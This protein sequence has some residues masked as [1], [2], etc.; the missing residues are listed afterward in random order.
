L[1]GGKSSWVGS[2]WFKQLKKDFGL[3]SN[4]IRTLK[5]KGINN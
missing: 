5:I 1:G 3:K 2:G 4:N